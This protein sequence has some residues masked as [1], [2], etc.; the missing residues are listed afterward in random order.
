MSIRDE[1]RQLGYSK[2]EEYFYKKDRELLRKMQE[3]AAGRK[4]ELAAK[5]KGQA[6]WMTC[7]KCGSELRE[8]RYHDLVDIDRCTGC[9]G[10]YLDQGELPIILKAQ[11]NRFLG[12]E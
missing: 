3:Q 11:V 8:E 7:P 1:M 10:L 5:H 12:E 9:S 4:K 2:E 6:Y